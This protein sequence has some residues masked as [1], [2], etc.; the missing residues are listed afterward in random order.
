MAANTDGFAIFTYSFGDEA[1]ATLPKEI[2]CRNSGIWYPVPDNGNIQDTMSRYYEYFAQGL[3]SAGGDQIRWTEY[4]DA[5]TND[6]LLTACAPAFS[7]GTSER[8]LLGVT[9]K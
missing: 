7:V 1:D 8:E 3:G 2:A 4:R 6:L 9:F 5:I